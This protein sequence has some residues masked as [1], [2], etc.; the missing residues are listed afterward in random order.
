M[1]LYTI[2]IV[3]S[4]KDFIILGKIHAYIQQ[5]QYI[6]GLPESLSCIFQL[7]FSFKSFPSGMN[8]VCGFVHLICAAIHYL[9]QDII[10]ITVNQD[11][12]NCQ[13]SENIM[14]DCIVIRSVILIGW[15]V[16]CPSSP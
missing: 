13:I 1:Y 10:D 2:L 16:C 5:I 15:I 9:I 3:F 12:G 11:H 4:Y 14:T 7:G 8:N 6:V